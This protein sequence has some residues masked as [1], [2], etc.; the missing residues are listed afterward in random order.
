M[1]YAGLK[2]ILQDSYFLNNGFITLI[3]NWKYILKIFSKCGTKKES[4]NSKEN[5][6][7]VENHQLRMKASGVVPSQILSDYFHD[8]K[9]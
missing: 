4:H 7:P 9:K 6:S 2:I 1:L 8:P 3:P 5:I